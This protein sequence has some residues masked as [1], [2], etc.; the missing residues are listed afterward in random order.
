MST[1]TSTGKVLPGQVD[2][3]LMDDLLTLLCQEMSAADLEDSLRGCIS[4][5][6]FQSD[7][8]VLDAPTRAELYGP[9][10]LMEILRAY[11]ER[12]TK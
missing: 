3:A 11:A 7:E 12:R 9:F 8:L 1:T 6:L 2:Q 10:R 4:L 5:I